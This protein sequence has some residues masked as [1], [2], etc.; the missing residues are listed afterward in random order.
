M[1]YYVD[2]YI[3]PMLNEVEYHANFGAVNYFFKITTLNIDCHIIWG[4][5]LSELRC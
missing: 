5:V 2:P 3:D 1:M 4:H